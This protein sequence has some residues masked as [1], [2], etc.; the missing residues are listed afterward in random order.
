MGIFMGIGAVTP[1]AS[2]YKKYIRSLETKRANMMVTNARQAIEFRK[3]EDPREL[4]FQKQSFWGRGLGKSSIF[5]QEKERLDLIQAQ[6]NKRL[7]DQ[8]WYAR[9][10]KTMIKRKHHWEKVSQYYEMVDNIIGA[11]WGG[12]S[13]GQS[14]LSYNDVG[15]SSGG[16]FG[17]D[18]GSYNSGVGAAGGGQTGTTSGFTF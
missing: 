13:T 14:A 3:Q 6:R 12:G 8:L 18:Y 1:D 7:A 16:Y 17:A 2:R 15:A 11:V 9:K 10:Y 5:D 4:A